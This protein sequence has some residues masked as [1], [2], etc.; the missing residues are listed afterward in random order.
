MTGEGA[1]RAAL[2]FFARRGYDDADPWLVDEMVRRILLDDGALFR[3]VAALETHPELRPFLARY[4][5]LKRAALGEGVRADVR[6]VFS[7]NAMSKRPGEG[8]AP[9]FGWCEPLTRTVFIDRGPWEDVAGHALF[10]ESVVF[11][12]LGH[13]DLDRGHDSSFAAMAADDARLSIMDSFVKARVL[14]PGFADVYP[15]QRA[16]ALFQDVFFGRFGGDAALA[17][18]SMVEE[19][20]S[21]RGTVGNVI[22]DERPAPPAALFARFLERSL[23]ALREVE[24]RHVRLDRR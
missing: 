8:E 22:V 13:C 12:E 3:R 4:D 21:R 15:I 7:R 24:G 20:F 11:H 16:E 5:K 14:W 6:V 10:R 23:P 9:F 17:Y 19:L 1:R 18:G 2:E